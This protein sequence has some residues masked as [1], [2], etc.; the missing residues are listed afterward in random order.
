MALSFA[1]FASAA[2]QTATLSPIDLDPS[3]PYRLE[4]R[5]ISFGNAD[6]PTLHSYAVGEYDGKWLFISGRTN[7]V[8][9]FSSIAPDEN[10]PPQY[11]SRDVWVIDI[12][13]RESWRRSLDDASSGLTAAQVA[14]LSP[15]NNQFYQSGDTL[16][17]TGGYGVDELGN[18]VTF[19]TLS[20]INLPGLGN[21]VT[22]DAGNAADHI[23]QVRDPL[24]KV[25]GGAMVEIDGRTH[26]VFGQDFDGPYRP[27]SNG[28][29]TNQVRSFDILDDGTSLSI[30]N[31][32]SSV[33]NDA[34]RRRDLNVFPAIRPDENGVNPGLVVLSGV[35]TPTFGAWTVP[36]EV[37]AAGNPTMADP[38]APGTF[39][40]GM[41]NYYSAKVGLY[42]EAAG[43]MHEILLGGISLQYWNATSSSIVTDN[44]LPFVNDIT[45]IKIDAAG[46][47]TQNYL[48]QFPELLD[49]AGNR[50]RFGTNAEFLLADSI[51]TFENGVIKLDALHGQT[52][53]GHIFGGIVANAPHTQGS[54]ST[55][56]AASNQ[57]FE[58]L[59][60]PT[61]SGDFNYDGT[62]DAADY[63][64]W[65]DYG[66]TPTGYDTWRAH[67]G[68]TTGGGSSVRTT[69]TV[70]GPGTVVMLFV[71]SIG[72]F[73]Q[74][75]P[76]R[77]RR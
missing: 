47:Y 60:M 26:L 29:Y 54:P 42:S 25:T 37:D 4:V 52:V 21:W 39:K 48:G 19:D 72:M 40:Q 74:C 33:P 30:A 71:T 75:R 67:F 7:G 46:N 2:N 10:F 23:R 18:Y 69:T 55:R 28:T 65:R 68:E 53:L 6:L 15:T 62:V 66:G 20:A 41:N 35:F 44:G 61:L 63:V 45:S 32:S 51:P 57:I 43:E 76:T 3:L 27:A 77:R 11:Q 36:V 22:S 14:S 1:A 56:S 12:V 70:P 59:L 49:L 9:G 16:Y 8:H 58:V 5:P 13:N 50:L 73:C 64:V 38:A 24:V 34:Y 31:T 17:M